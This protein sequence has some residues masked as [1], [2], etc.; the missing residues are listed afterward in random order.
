MASLISQ[1]SKPQGE[2]PAGW[3]AQPRQ[4]LARFPFE[5]GGVFASC[6]MLWVKCSESVEAALDSAWQIAR[7]L[8]LLLL[9]ASCRLNIFV[10]ILFLPLLAEML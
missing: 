6:C 9:V 3:M 8:F 4:A 5:S 2:L 1:N 7:P 10:L